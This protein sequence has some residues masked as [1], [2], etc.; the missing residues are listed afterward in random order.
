LVNPTEKNPAQSTGIPALLE[1]VRRVR[2]G[3]YIQIT[4]DGTEVEAM[5]VVRT[6]TDE[7]VGIEQ[8]EERE[9]P[10]PQPEAPPQSK[11][12]REKCNRKSNQTW[13]A[14]C[15]ENDLPPYCGIDAARAAGHKDIRACSQCGCVRA[16]PHQTDFIDESNVYTA[17]DSGIPVLTEPALKMA[18]ETFQYITDEAASFKSNGGGG[19]GGGRN[20][21]KGG[22]KG[23]RGGGRG[24]GGKKGGRGKGRGGGRGANKRK[25][26]PTAL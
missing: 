13:S 7:L 18:K 4:S 2:L 16:H 3:D 14:Y 25:R 26:A 11:D 21:R 24:R 22:K 15:K 20:G 8:E 5:D 9:T 6:V 23:G 10:R 12:I 1:L 17:P 19:G